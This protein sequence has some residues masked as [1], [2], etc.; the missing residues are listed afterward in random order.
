MSPPASRA[1][2]GFPGAPLD[3]PTVPRVQVRAALEG[4]V[5]TEEE[6]LDALPG[7]L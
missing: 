2:S 6:E 5:P 4:L 1:L 3:H 7:G